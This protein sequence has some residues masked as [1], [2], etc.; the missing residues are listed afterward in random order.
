MCVNGKIRPVE[1][2]LG[3]GMGGIKDRGG[4]LNYV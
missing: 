3:M 1:I 4:E 2:I